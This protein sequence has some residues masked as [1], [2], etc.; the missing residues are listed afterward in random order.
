MR[1]VTGGTNKIYEEWDRKNRKERHM[2]WYII[3]ISSS[4]RKPRE[5]A[6]A[7]SKLSSFLAW[8]QNISEIRTRTNFY[9]SEYFLPAPVKLC[10]KLPHI[11]RNYNSSDIFRNWYSRTFNKTPE[12]L[13]Y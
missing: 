5:F 13:L 8:V 1:I 6:I 2:D 3:Y 12:S 10:H 7:S 4:T 9:Y 11:T